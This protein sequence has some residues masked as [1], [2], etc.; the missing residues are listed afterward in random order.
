MDKDTNLGL[1]GRAFM[2]TPWTDILSMNRLTSEERLERLNFLL[3]R[4]WRPVYFFIRRKGR[5]NEEAKDLTQAFFAQILENDIFSRADPE[6]G[7]F[8]NYLL[9]AAKN[10]IFSKEGNLTAGKASFPKGTKFIEQM[11][12]AEFPRFEAFHETTPEK[13]FNRQ[14]AVSLLNTVF[15]RL[16]E[17]CSIR[18]CPETFDVFEKRFVKYVDDVYGANRKIAEEMNISARD[19]ET[20]YKKALRWYRFLLREEVAAYV[21]NKGDIEDEIRELWRILGK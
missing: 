20:H 17:M 13:E 1:G 14:W 4:Y 5:N 18:E 11:T 21:Q 2:T 16:K 15:S 9:T 10:F 19:V 6:K 7:R 8:R 3:E 12:S